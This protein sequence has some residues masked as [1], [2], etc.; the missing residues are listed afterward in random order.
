MGLTL[1]SQDT[2]SLGMGSIQVHSA[3]DQPLQASIDLMMGEEE[4]FSNLSVKLASSE[5]YKKVGLDRSF[6]PNNI[7]VSVDE[8]NPLLIKVSSAGPIS[9][10]I[11]SLLLDVNWGNGRI[12]R[13]FTILLDPPVYSNTQITTGATAAVVSNDYQD[14][15]PEPVVVEPVE[16]VVEA[17]VET[18]TTDYTAD[19]SEAE[20]EVIADE[21]VAEPSEEP[22]SSY[23][24]SGVDA[25]EVMSGDTLWSIANRNKPSALTVNQM[26]AALFNS[27]PQAFMNNNINQLVKGSR[28][29]IPTASEI[30][31]ISQ[32]DALDMV[33]SHNDSWAPSQTTEESY[34]SFQTEE[35]VYEPAEE[36]ATETVDYGVEL[37]G[38]TDQE[39]KRKLQLSESSGSRSESLNK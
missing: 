24:A 34:A 11:V 32:T 31:A 13:E 7:S 20:A 5:D 17:P 37:A 35:P 10:P 28:L 19:E 9:E 29:M 12:L 36:P 26:M 25:V 23:D 14:S 38:S 2:Q 6:V 1:A 22:V 18:G 3:L 30:Q 33:R 27:N 8:D 21:V 4:D 39:E 16:E 15:T